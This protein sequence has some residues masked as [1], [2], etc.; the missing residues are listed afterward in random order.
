MRL[1]ESTDEGVDVLTLEGEIDLQYAPV[2]RTLLVGK[3]KA[4]CPAVIL[5]MSAV[6]FIDSTGLAAIIEYFRD[7]SAFGGVLCLTGLNATLKSILEIVRLDQLIAAFA[8]PADAIA[9]LKRGE[10][11]A[12]AA[13][14]FHQPAA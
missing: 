1:K 10:V 14:L 6:T 8:T 12:P 11:S 3:V 9:A 2:L 5:N 7:A 4:R 13:A